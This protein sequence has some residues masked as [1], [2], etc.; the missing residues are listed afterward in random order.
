MH[1]ALRP[2]Q[3]MQLL[4]SR[5][6]RMRSPLKQ[7]YLVGACTQVHST[8][9]L[10]RNSNRNRMP[11]LHI[12]CALCAT[13]KRSRPPGYR[14]TSPIRHFHDSFRIDYRHKPLQLPRLSFALALTLANKFKIE[15][16]RIH[17]AVKL[18]FLPPKSRPNSDSTE[19][20]RRDQAAFSV[21]KKMVY[22]ERWVLS[23]LLL[24]A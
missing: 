10:L 8:F 16:Y 12:L 7:I 3:K 19:F 6:A 21:T 13:R 4:S 5:S 22:F 17:F 14:I 23:V 11:L 1:R 24:S 18:K 15:Y 9:F 2:T 20:S